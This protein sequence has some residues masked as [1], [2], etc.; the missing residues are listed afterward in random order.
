MGRKE[1]MNIGISKFF[2]SLLLAFL[3]LLPLTLYATELT[4]QDLQARVSILE[5]EAA[6]IWTAMAVM[7]VFLM[8]GGFML[9]EAGLVRAKNTINTAQKN[10]S[11]TLISTIIFYLF[12]YNLMFGATQGG[13]LGSFTIDMDFHNIEHTFFLYQVVFCSMVATVVSGALAERIKFEA[14]MISTIFITAIIYPVFGHWAWG[15]KVIPDNTSFLIEAGFIDFAGGT[16]VCAL[17]GWVALAGL[18]VIGPRIGRYNADGT[19]NKMPANNVV[20]SGFGMIVLWVGALAF[21]S[22]LAHA[23]SEDV[24]HIM[25]NTILAGAFAGLASLV[26]GRIRDG[27]FRPERCIY[28]VLGGIVAVAAGCHVFTVTDTIIVG[29]S[30]GLA[31]G[32]TFYI[33]VDIFKIDDVVCAVP[34]NGICGALGT[35]LIGPL[36]MAEAFGDNSRME[37]FL[38]QAQGVG[39]SFLWAFFVTLIFY[40]ILNNVYGFRVTKEEEIMGL[41]SA[42]HGVTMGTGLLQERFKDIVDGDGDLTIRL[43]ETTGD[44]SA[45]IAYL[46][47]RFVEKIQYLLINIEQNS[48][49]ITSSSDKLSTVSQTFSEGFKKITN[50]SETVSN[51]TGRIAN[52][53]DSIAKVIGEVSSN[54]S[55]ISENASM[56]SDNV[57]SVSKDVDNMTESIGEI[58]E[59]T[60]GATQVAAKAKE[61][62]TRATDTMNILNHTASGIDEI[63]SFIN[64]IAK[65]TNLLALNATI[66]ASRAGEAGKS[67]AVVANEVKALA[68]ETSKATENISQKVTQIQTQTSDANTIVSELNEIIGTINRSLGG[69]SEAVTNQGAATDSISKNVKETTMGAQSIA[70]EIS[71]IAKG[72]EDVSVSV[73]DAANES[74]EVLGT[75]KEFT[76]D[77]DSNSS[78]A[79]KVKVATQDLSSVANELTKLVNQYKIK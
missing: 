25:S 44:E 68:D 14:Y 49:I 20:L 24:A 64:E 1:R 10:L 29:I 5:S 65:Q 4:L 47:N 56:V 53:L 13:W 45:E 35:L 19:A 76:Q 2:I 55:A 61:M 60:T 9:F 18:I 46:F 34:I 32:L 15:N 37:Q 69:I 33:L 11:D 42:E 77:A 6:H 71:S 51:S 17:G 26:W 30:S 27:L 23:G 36:G 79:E 3:T 63:L 52:D 21:N 7:V 74:N 59:N 78:N 50:E 57:L 54:V 38:A 67:F 75:V 73:K 8:K 16:V 40:K 12:G 22:G 28:G 43:D 66:E 70:Q 58:V 39:A 72:S 48:K 31:V 62:I 41:N